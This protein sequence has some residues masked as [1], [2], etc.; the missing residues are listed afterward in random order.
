MVY[1]NCE[2][3]N[4]L[5]ECWICGC[6]S[7]VVTVVVVVVLAL[8][9]AVGGRAVVVEVVGVVGLEV[10]EVVFLIIASL[11]RPNPP[12]PNTFIICKSSSFVIFDKTLVL[13]VVVLLGIEPGLEEEENCF[14]RLVRI[15]R[16]VVLLS[17]GVRSESPSRGVRSEGAS[18]GVR[19]KGPSRGVCKGVPDC[20]ALRSSYSRLIR[21]LSRRED[22]RK[23]LPLQRGKKCH[24]YEG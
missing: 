19:R 22:S 3:D 17:R 9:I 16:G 1:D 8:V 14:L 24:N 13:V 12:M 18:R 20:A 2:C 23:A 4:K 11:T 21:V 10:V 15:L 7:V 5:C 6:G